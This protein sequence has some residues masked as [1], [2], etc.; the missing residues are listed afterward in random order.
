[1]AS[2]TNT[3]KLCSRLHSHYHRLHTNSALGNTSKIGKFQLRILLNDGGRKVIEILSQ[4]KGGQKNIKSEKGREEQQ[5]QNSMAE[6]YGNPSNKFAFFSLFIYWHV[7]DITTQ[8]F[9]FSA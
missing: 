7:N 3:N 9:I 8:Y 2:L 1:M 5:K 4:N 6:L